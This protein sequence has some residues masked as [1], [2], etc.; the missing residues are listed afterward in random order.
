M[1]ITMH[2]PA[3]MADTSDWGNLEWENIEREL[4]CSARELCV[5]YVALAAWKTFSAPKGSAR[6]E[7][8]LDTSDL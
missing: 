5:G 1:T 2:G 3:E 4:Y 8:V 7:R 6:S